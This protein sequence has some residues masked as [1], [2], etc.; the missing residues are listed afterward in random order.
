VNEKRTVGTAAIYKFGTDL[1][2]ACMVPG[3][4]VA[5][6]ITW[7]PDDR[8]MYF[9]CSWERTVFA[10]D[11][12]IDDGAL[13][14]RRVFVRFE[15]SWGAPDGATVDSEGGVWIAHHDGW[16]ITRFT[17]DGEVDRV[18][19]MPVPRPTSCSFGGDKL[20][21]LY[22]TSASAGVADHDLAA[23]PLSGSL[24]AINV[25]QQGMPEPMFGG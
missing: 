23:A 2:A 5:N 25:G 11:F 18:V 9:A 22:V 21:V 14:N 16:R 15:D 17:P 20:D 3:I 4:T 12:D 19:P 7:S 8:T 13:F 6:T 24:F 10:C 1:Q